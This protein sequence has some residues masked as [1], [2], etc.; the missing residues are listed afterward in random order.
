V[1]PAAR[2]VPQFP[3]PKNKEDPLKKTLILSAV[4]ALASLSNVALAADGAG[5]F[6]RAEIGRSDLDVQGFGDSDSSY[7]LRGGYYFNKHFAV[8][9]FATN[10]YE[11]HVG[12]Y[13]VG[14]RGVGAGLVGKQNFGS[15][16]NGLFVSGRGGLSW[17]RGEVGGDHEDS[18]NFYVGVGA[19]YDFNDTFGLSLNYDLHKTEFDGIDVDVDTVTLGGEFRF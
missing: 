14:V 12:F 9:G 10:L 16:G 7:N 13:E 4:L 15:D 2:R 18:A 3:L 8:E 17:L 6:I 5:G 19:G 11:S 1:A